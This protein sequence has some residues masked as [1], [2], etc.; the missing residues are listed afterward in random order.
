MVWSKRFSSNWA[1][2]RFTKELTLFCVEFE[3]LASRSLF[4][5]SKE[6]DSARI[7][8]AS[9]RICAD[10]DTVRL[11][12]AWSHLL[13]AR[14]YCLHALNRDELATKR[15][16]LLV[17]KVKIRNWRKD[18]VERLLVN[19][20]P[21]VQSVCEAM[22]HLDEYT[23]N[24]YQKIWLAAEQLQILVIA[25]GIAFGMLIP[26][27]CF[28]HTHWGSAS[29]KLS[30]IASWSWTMIAAVLVFGLEGGAF[31]CAQRLFPSIATERIPDRV[32]NRWIMLIRAL[33]GSIAGLA[34]YTFFQADFLKLQVFVPDNLAGGLGI[35]FVFGF[36]GEKLVS[37]FAGSL[38]TREDA[39]NKN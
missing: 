10:S 21:T 16:V 20:T 12:T 25:T 28:V 37:H 14:R 30:G 15:T 29:E 13:G 35:A 33:F 38:L 26:L 11:E 32:A 4:D 8:L 22:Y 17:E 2:E 6:C 36:A 18:A 39:Q 9:A 27:F 24:G 1:A 7:L 3:R 31:S 19:D 5:Q 34:G 23:A